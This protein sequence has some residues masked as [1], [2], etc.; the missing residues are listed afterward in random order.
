MTVPAGWVRPS[1][2]LKIA[3]DTLFNHPNTPIFVSKQL[4]QHLV[5]SN[6]SP[7]YLQR[8]AAYSRTTA[9]EY[10]AICRP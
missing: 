3:L 7:A 5:T 9:R 4:I 1:G 2:D 10:A 8:V 6:P